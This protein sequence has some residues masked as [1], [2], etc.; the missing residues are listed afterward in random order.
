MGRPAVAARRPAPEG[1]D[2]A[3]ADRR[4]TAGPPPD[5]PFSWET[6]GRAL[7]SRRRSRAPGVGS[8]TR[9][10]SRGN[11][12]RDERGR[13]AW[14]AASET[15]RRARGARWDLGE[16]GA[17]SSRASNPPSR[18][19]RRGGRRR[20]TI[21]GAPRTPPPRRPS[22]RRPIS[23]SADPAG[24]AGVYRRRAAEFGRGG[25]RA[26]TCGR[27]SPAGG[28]SHWA[29]RR[30]QPGDRRWPARAAGGDGAADPRRGHGEEEAAGWLLS[31]EEVS[32]R[33]RRR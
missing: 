32:L 25:N 3:P 29:E 23:R 33:S 18:Q 10:S 4:A 8:A 28:A 13:G 24:G 5:E 20:W 11:G 26:S 30:L 7:P 17:C 14:S 22:P 27:R 12:A 19:L 1:P 21:S 9:T 16:P 6:R 31:G 15:R 2:P